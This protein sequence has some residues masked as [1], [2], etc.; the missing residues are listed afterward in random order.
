MDKM[1]LFNQPQFTQSV[2]SFGYDAEHRN[3][4]GWRSIVTRREEE[5]RN[6]EAWYY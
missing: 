1:S 3:Q 6:Q 2:S 5:H 4:E